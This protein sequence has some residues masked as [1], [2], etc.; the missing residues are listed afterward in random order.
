MKTPNLL[1]SAATLAMIAAPAVL[2]AHQDP[3]A[4]KGEA[5]AAKQNDTAKQDNAGKQDNAPKQDKAQ[6]DRAIIQAQRWSYPLA[7]CPISGEKLGPK[8]SEFVVQ[9]RLVRT[10][11][12]DC[13]AQVV[14]DPSPMLKKIDAAVIAQQKADYPLATDPVTGAKLDDKAIDYVYGTRLVRL[15]NKDSVAAFEKDPKSAMAKVD[16]AYIKAQTATY[17]LKT[18]VVSGEDLGGMGEAYDKLYGTRLVRF[19]CSSCTETFEKDSGTYLK[20]L[21]DAKKPAK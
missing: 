12:N 16:A 10:C 17:P 4:R 9:G 8:M 20:K 21:D 7:T 3:Q 14:A 13:K 11:C 1:L 2:A 6:D 18:C 15:A 19:C 5:P